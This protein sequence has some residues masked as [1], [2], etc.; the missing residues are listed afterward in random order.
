[1]SSPSDWMEL[2]HSNL[3]H[4]GQVGV[5]P[6]TTSTTTAS[7]S[8]TTTTSRNNNLTLDQ[9]RIAKP[10]A[11]RR[12]RASQRAPATL[13]KTDLKNFKAM[14]Q[15]FTGEVPMRSQ[16]FAGTNRTIEFTADD[17]G[18]CSMRVSQ[19]EHPPIHMQQHNMFTIHDH[20]NMNIT[21]GADQGFSSRNE[22]RSFDQ[23]H[24][25]FRS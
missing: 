18:T 20:N 8:T 17:V 16:I 21:F 25:M 5:P 11:K 14:V 13:I 6:P 4:I 23:D 15:Q 9:G 3:T 24:D 12:S 10:A 1:M 7:T 2:Y 19:V 22:N